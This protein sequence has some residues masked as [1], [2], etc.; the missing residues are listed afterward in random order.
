MKTCFVFFFNISLCV[1]MCMC[2]CACVCVCVCV[3]VGV[4]GWVGGF[5]HACVCVENDNIT[6]C[7]EL[8][9]NLHLFPKVQIK[10]SHYSLLKY[11]KG[12]V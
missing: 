6:R 4:C 12:N 2:V 7:T 11:L 9:N 1:C 8:W 10:K 5:V 3:C